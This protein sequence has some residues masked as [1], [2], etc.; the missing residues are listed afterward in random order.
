MVLRASGMATTTPHAVP[1]MILRM[2]RPRTAW[3]IEFA[4]PLSVKPITDLSNAH[5]KRAGS[6]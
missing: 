6:Y 5:E 1:D 4:H 2:I 3:R